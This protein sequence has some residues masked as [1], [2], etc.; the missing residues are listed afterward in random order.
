MRVFLNGELLPKEAAKVSVFDRG[1]LFGDGVYEVIPVYN[2]KL[3][4]FSEHISRLENSLSAINI[5]STY[6]IDEW[7]R[8]CNDV[9][10]ECTVPGDKTIYIEVTRGSA[11]EREHLS[12]D[13][14]KPTVF[15]MCNPISTIKYNQGVS[16]ITHDDI[17]WFRCYVKAIT[18]LPNIL[19][20][21]LAKDTDGSYEAILIRDN[22]VTE[23]AASNVFVVHDDMITTPPKNENILAGITRDLLVELMQETGMVINEE[24]VAAQSLFDADEIWL[25]GTTTGVAPV[26]KLNGN[27]VGDS[28]PGKW[29]KQANRLFIDYISEFKQT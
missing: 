9:V 10:K 7:Q 28:T 20:R 17:R 22:F 29:W 26:V 18:L 14:I 23:G 16:V 24:P 13:A 8:I 2:D 27:P 21:Q 11:G 4:R 1:F 15:V 5:K 6:S 12:K 25:T 19:L 3:L